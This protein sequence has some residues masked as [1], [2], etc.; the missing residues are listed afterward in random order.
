MATVN[1]A[2]A[3]DLNESDVYS[4][5]FR[6]WDTKTQKSLPVNE[7]T[8]YEALNDDSSDVSSS[9]EDAFKEEKVSLGKRIINFF[10]RM[11]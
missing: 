10:R 8:L 9:S 11:F 4:F 2:K 6:L 7:D 5:I 3:L 1:G